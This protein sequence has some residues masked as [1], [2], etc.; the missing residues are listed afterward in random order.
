MLLSL[1]FFT[2]THHKN[3]V[4]YSHHVEDDICV[5]A[6]LEMHIFIVKSEPKNRQQNTYFRLLPD[7]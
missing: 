7:G 5:L 6:R 3:F 1:D 2:I 4:A